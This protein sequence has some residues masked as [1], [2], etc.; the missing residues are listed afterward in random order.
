MIGEP[1]QGQGRKN[2]D[3]LAR[4]GG[5]RPARMRTDQPMAARICGNRCWQRAS[6]RGNC[7][8]ERKFAEN[9]VI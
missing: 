1:N 9:S 2:V 6:D 7:S 8:V 4:P 3:V 5:L